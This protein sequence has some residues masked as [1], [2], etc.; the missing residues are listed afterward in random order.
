MIKE[1]KLNTI[2]WWGISAV[3]L[4]PTAF[5]LAM[6]QSDNKTSL[7]N[8]GILAQES[9]LEQKTPTQGK[10]SKWSTNSPTQITEQTHQSHG[11]IKTTIDKL[12]G[13][14]RFF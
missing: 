9:S 10:Q 3:L 4:S 14:I 6:K 1:K 7:P 12:L 11:W 5:P 13:P 2:Y 8:E